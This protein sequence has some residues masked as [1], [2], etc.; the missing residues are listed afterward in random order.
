MERDYSLEPSKVRADGTFEVANANGRGFSLEKVRG[1]GDFPVRV[2]VDDSTVPLVVRSTDSYT[3]AT[4]FQKLVV[5]TTPGGGVPG[6]LWRVVIAPSI[7]EIP[8]TRLRRNRR[9]ATLVAA[10]AARI[11]FDIDSR[12]YPDGFW[13]LCNGDGGNYYVR[14][15]APSQFST[16]RGAGWDISEYT[17]VMLVVEQFSQSGPSPHLVSLGAT[18]FGLGSTNAWDGIAFATCGTVNNF[19][20]GW[21]GLCGY[22]ALGGPAALKDDYTEENPRRFPAAWFQVAVGAGGLNLDAFQGDS[23][24][25]WLRIYAVGF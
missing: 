18:L 4:T 8:R 19:G 10:D 25:Y 24:N 17:R 1:R 6:D 14:P 5:D 9:G 3:H 20:F 12:E 16:A 13:P 21:N 23:Y 11:L 7:E 2:T 22:A 15:D